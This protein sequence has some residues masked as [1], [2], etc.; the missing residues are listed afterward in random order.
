MFMKDLVAM[1]MITE[2][3]QMYLVHCFQYVNSSFDHP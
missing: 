1:F 3:Q 2:G